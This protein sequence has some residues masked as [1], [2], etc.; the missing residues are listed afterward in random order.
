MD[1]E[2]AAER[3]HE[4]QAFSR[5]QDGGDAVRTQ[6]FVDRQS[7]RD[8]A[9]VAHG[10]LRFL[11]QLAQ[12]ARAW[13][14]GEPVP[15]EMLGKLTFVTKDGT[16]VTGDEALNNFTRRGLLTQKEQQTAA[17]RNHYEQLLSRQ[18]QQWEGWGNDPVR[19]ETELEDMGF[20]PQ[21]EHIARKKVNEYAQEMRMLERL[22]IQDP[23]TGQWVPDKQARAQMEQVFQA[24]R[25]HERSARQAAKRAQFAASQVQQQQGNNAHDQRV[26]KVAHQMAQFG[27]RALR[28]LGVPNTP[29]VRQLVSR[30][31]ALIHRPNTELTYEMVKEAAKNAKDLHDMEREQGLAKRDAANPRRRAAM[32]RGT[33]NPRVGAAPN[34]QTQNANRARISDFDAEMKEQDKRAGY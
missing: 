15:E 4:Q 3:S 23:R 27:P 14:E 31:M 12:Q 8:C 25:E 26:Q 11:D 2:A 24:K 18:R 16:V 10:V 34:P 22:V 28:E 32:P 5:S 1:A 13:L 29:Y 19:M 17:T 6:Q 7:D 33:G 20:G 21:L 9:T 30:E